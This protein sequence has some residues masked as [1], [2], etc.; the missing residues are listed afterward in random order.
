M[1]EKPVVLINNGTVPCTL[2]KL[3]V[4]DNWG[5]A[6]ADFSLKEGPF[7]ETSLSPFGLLPVWI[8]FSPHEDYVG[9]LNIEYVDDLAGSVEIAV[10]LYGDKVEHCALPVAD[11][12]HGYDNAVA[13]EL[14]TLDG[15]GSSAGACGSSIYEGGYIWFL[16]SKPEG[17][18][19]QLNT[20][21]SCTT[22]FVPD[23][24]GQYEVALMVYDGTSFFQS[25]LATTVVSVG[26][27]D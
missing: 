3:S 6:S 27:V 22:S 20:E 24:A 15:C 2:N 14:L 16:L 5:S 21:G 26:P 11:P 13:G 25:E 8:Q 4:T 10:D 12:G 18:A 17:I 9:Q 7:G 1:I 23:V 19:A